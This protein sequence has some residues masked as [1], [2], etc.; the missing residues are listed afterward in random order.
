MTFIAFGEW[1]VGGIYQVNVSP[2][3]EPDGHKIVVPDVGKVLTTIQDKFGSWSVTIK[4]CSHGSSRSV[5]L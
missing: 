5:S 4:P 1:K 3:F 2:G